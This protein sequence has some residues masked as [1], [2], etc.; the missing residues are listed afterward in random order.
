M[1]AS[2]SAR[3]FKAAALLA[4]LVLSALPAIPVADAQGDA[5]PRGPLSVNT[6]TA[7]LGPQKDSGSVDTVNGQFWSTGNTVFVHVNV[8]NAGLTDVTVPVILYHD[9]LDPATNQTAFRCDA[10][11]SRL[12][13]KALSSNWYN[14]SFTVP[15]YGFSAYNVTVWVNPQTTGDVP[16]DR[17]KPGCS[18]SHQAEAPGTGAHVAK[19]TYIHDAKPDYRITDVA[20]CV[21]P[22]VGSDED[23]PHAAT[24]ADIGPDDTW[25]HTSFTATGTANAQ[26][27]FIKAY[28]ENVGNWEQNTTWD[29]YTGNPIPFRFPYT[30][31][32]SGAN[33]GSNTDATLVQQNDGGLEYVFTSNRSSA[34]VGKLN[35][36][37]AYGNYSVR[38]RINDPSPNN[39]VPQLP[40]NS[41]IN[42]TRDAKF[43]VRGYD[44]VAGVNM[45]SFATDP[46]HPYDYPFQPDGNFAI[47]GNVTLWNLGLYN[48]QDH[49]NPVSIRAY[50]DSPTS[51]ITFGPK[52]FNVGN[53]STGVVEIP[54]SFQVHSSDDGQPG[55][56]SKGV[57]TI[58]VD[59]DDSDH[60]AVGTYYET[61]ETNNNATVSI[62]F[63]LGDSDGPH[64][65]AVPDIT[66]GGPLACSPTGCANPEITYTHPW[67]SFAVHANVTEGDY[68]Q[69][70]LL[71]VVANFT[72]STNKSVYQTYPMILG[73]ATNNHNWSIT[74]RNFSYIGPGSIQNWDLTIEAKDPFGRTQKA[75]WPNKLVLEKWPIQTL[76]DTDILLSVDGNTS[77]A[78][79]D[80]YVTPY[81]DYTPPYMLL[82]YRNWTGI[83]NND[84]SSRDQIRNVTNLGVVYHQPNG[85]NQSAGIESL[86][87]TCPLDDAGAR[88]S[89][90][91]PRPGPDG[92]PW[93]GTLGTGADACTGTAESRYHFRSVVLSTSAAGA[94]IYGVE[95]RIA[96]LSG[97]V[98]TIWRN[99]TMQD[100]L[101]QLEELALRDLNDATATNKS[102]AGHTLQIHVNASDD[103]DINR[104]AVYMTWTKK[105][106]STPTFNITLKNS[107][108]QGKWTDGTTHHAYNFTYNLSVGRDATL[109]QS[110]AFLWSIVAQDVNGNWNR[111]AGREFTLEE[112]TLPTILKELTGADPAEQE[113]RQPVTFYAHA[114]GLYNPTLV[115][116]VKDGNNVALVDNVV[117]NATSGKGKDTN[118]TY[119]YAFN[120]TG[121]YSWEIDAFSSQGGLDSKSGIATGSVVVSD[122]LGPRIELKSPDVRVGP[123]LYAP[124]SPTL[125]FLVYDQQGVD[126]G[127]FQLIVDGQQVPVTR[128]PAQGLNGY[129]FQWT[130]PTPYADGAEVTVNVSVFDL[131]GL[132]PGKVALP[133]YSNFTFKVDAKAPSARVTDFGPR[134]KSGASGVWNVSMGTRFTIA[135]D[136]GADSPTPVDAIWFSIVG[137]QRSVQAR[138]TGPFSLSDYRDVYVGST[139]YTIT[140]WAYDAVQNTDRVHAFQQSFFLDDEA[141]HLAL[142]LTQGRY[143]NWTIVDEQTGVK[144]VTLWARAGNAPYTAYPMAKDPVGDVWR[145]ILPEAVKGQTITYYVQAVDNVDN[146]ADGVDSFGSP[147]SPYGSF[148]V[149]NHEPVVKITSPVVGSRVSRVVD[150]QWTATDADADA[151]TVTVFYKA[152]GKDAFTELT[153]QE[154]SANGRYQLDT[155][156]FPD[157]EYTFRVAASDNT[158]SKSDET[159]VTIINAASAIGGVSPVGDVNPGDSVLITAQILK[160]GATVEAQVYRDNKLVDSFAMNDEG[161][162]GDAVA[163]DHTYS[164]RVPVSASGDYSVTIVAHYDEG[165][166]GRTDTLTNA[167]TWSAALTPAYI[168]QTYAALLVLLAL[169]AVVGVAIAVFVVIK[170]KG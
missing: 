123:Q 97:E 145:G 37:Q 9:Q 20:W 46:A 105:G 112:T 28:L 14:Q 32:V 34:L 119:R 120:S 85:Q 169:L 130:A 138:Y 146:N 42:K 8:S 108:E 106:Q 139:V 154:G 115:L 18:W 149:G 43:E 110:G 118:Y 116:T 7:F 88:N 98:R 125:L 64:F 102:F 47:S 161:R 5:I 33:K 31:L 147:A 83:I 142:P 49:N 121:T 107:T 164:A 86:I 126:N 54:I 71:T 134:Y 62:Y 158:V 137:G 3:R 50:V 75:T 73:R 89:V 162:D 38:V 157:G 66:R 67:E 153:R 87:R 53:A 6:A 40:M 51:G 2:P 72:L 168:V 27:T 99:V 136:A 165:G 10:T 133:S 58:H 60:D 74:V 103:F 82:A 11:T 84:N 104:S 127:T 26:H 90:F 150:L 19:F 22:N 41:T 144:A 113:I 131:S 52:T 39:P 109:N 23:L 159:T 151:L 65:N 140:V 56:I 81:A 128:S 77:A 94:G 135:A 44:F 63:K 148:K 170:R 78:A 30:T 143:L 167:A 1:V 132:L 68:E 76:N 24:C 91:S 48:A 141:P 111:T 101:P 25:N 100:Q 13:I 59:V 117:M 152:P 93:N 17:L 61:D 45:T 92:N 163:N 124:A 122:N 16:A 96:D 35:L 80:M 57:H 79:Q 166:V 21:D 160:A 70:G 15:A 156:K 4:C 155:S 36:Y 69:T 29:P 95:L 55:Y 114:N 129:Y 12:T